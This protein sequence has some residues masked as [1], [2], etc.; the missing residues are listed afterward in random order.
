MWDDDT[1]YAVIRGKDARYDGQF[2]TAVR[3]TGIYCRPSCPARTPARANVSF[4]PTAAAAQHAGFRSCRRCFPDDA[5]SS[6]RWKVGEDVASRAMRLIDDG[7]VEREGVAGLARR[8]GYTERHVSRVLTDE[9]GA[10]PQALAIAHRLH[11]AR[12]LL[13]T[14]ALPVGEVAFAAGFGSVRQFNDA[15]RAAWALTP[16]EVRARA[17]A[18]PSQPTGS[19]RL[20]LRLRHRA[21]A[22]V[23]RT[24]AFLGARAVEGAE[25]WDGVAYTRTMRLPHGGGTVT[26]APADGHVRAA[27]ELADVRDLGAAVAR[28]R[29]LLDLDA[30]P[31]AVDEALAADPRLA[32]LVGAAP[33]LRVPGAVDPFEMVVRAVVGQQVSVAGARRTLG[34]IVARFGAEAPAASSL[35]RAFPT[36]E[37]LA[38]VDPAIGLLPQ[39]RWRAISAVARALLDGSLDLGPGADR[40]EARRALL[41]V[42]GI[43]PWTVEYVALRALGDP[44]AFPAGDLVLTQE[45]GLD[46]RALAAAA[47]AWRPWR[48]YAALHLWTAAADR[49]RA[50]APG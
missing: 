10:S 26:L 43:G 33:G 28:C 32:P 12:T 23:G 5:P 30:D 46:A 37:A 9:L 47:E 25:A 36:P 17:A 27:L 20:E 29:R 15:A 35:S 2:V 3:T 48:A 4:Y 22:Q 42:P 39:A 45:T 13:E 49:A 24:L 1:R 34:T 44:D 7:V 6:P 16:T 14:T 31:L 40:A 19:T 18:A 38:D 11:H 41:A 8:L 50:D 21:P